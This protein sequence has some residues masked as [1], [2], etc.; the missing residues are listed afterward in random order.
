MPKL[1]NTTLLVTMSVVAPEGV[2]YG[3]LYASSSKIY[4]TSSQGNFDLTDAKG[5]I[6]V[7][8]YTS[9]QTTWSPP[10]NLKYAKILAIGGGG[11]GGGGAKRSGTTPAGNFTSGGTGAAGSNIIVVTFP[12][13]V[14]TRP[15]YTVTIGGGGNGG[16]GNTS[17]G[18]GNGIGGANG[19]NTTL[20]SGSI[21]LVRAGAAGEAQSGRPGLD[22]T[23]GTQQ[24]GIMLGTN[25]IPTIAPY[26]LPAWSGGHW[27]AGVTGTAG[28]PTYV[29]NTNTPFNSADAIGTFSHAMNG[30]RGCASGGAGGGFTSNTTNTRAG[31][32]SGVVIGNT[33]LGTGSPGTVGTGNAGSNGVADLLDIMNLFYFSGSSTVTSSLGIGSGGCGGASGNLTGTIGGGVGGNGAT[34]G[35]GGG[36]GGSCTG[37]ANAG[38][39]G[40]GGD[41]YMAIIEYY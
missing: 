17:A 26:N 21:T 5:Y 7:R 14:F 6:L 1:L 41:G 35:A 8:E 18:G 37:S 9:G 24:G 27:G 30:R 29:A 13:S 23:T 19:G 33:I 3:N 12:R 4:F 38:N 25:A 15:E 10:L 39:G 36:G 11:G 31:S 22:N 2:G 40:S 28:N 20:A 34:I 32:G 16:L